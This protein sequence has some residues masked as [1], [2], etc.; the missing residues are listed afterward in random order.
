[1]LDIKEIR[2]N[3]DFYQKE[4][5]SRKCEVNLQQL[6]DLDQSRKDIQTQLQEVQEKRN[7]LSKQ[8]GIKKSQGED[9]TEIMQEVGALK[10]KMSELSDQEADV[11][12]QLNDQLSALP[13]IAFEDV[14]EGNSEDENKEIMRHG[15]LCDFSFTPRDHEEI[16]NLLNY[17]SS[18]DAAK[19]SGARF[20]ILYDKL[21]RLERALSQFMLDVQTQEFGYTEVSPPL[22]VK[23]NVAYGTGQLPKFSEDLFKTTNDFYLIPT[24]EMPLTNIVAG[25]ILDEDILPIRFTALTPCFRSEAGAAGKDTKGMIRQ[26][27]F[28][29][30]ELVSIT[31]QE[32]SQDEHERMTN[33]A[34]EILKRLELPY[35]KMLLC[36]GDMGFSARKTYDLEVWLPGQNQYREISSCSNCS[37]FQARRMNARYRTKSDKKIHFAH[38]LNGSGLAVGRALIAVIENYQTE[39]GHIRV[40]EV[41]QPYMNGLEII[42]NEKN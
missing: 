9:A 32:D 10:T 36:R 34:E 40:P 28:Y 39:E 27:Q 30:V 22:L 16:G 5:A 17:M 4:L 38:T 37:D 12:K 24:A 26:H 42:K 23:D 18:E 29:K 25:E 35:R 15:D 20:T 6:I 11:K 31:K 8:I 14:P 41:L 21:A 3:P 33:A 2:E 7:S 1:M 19:L 13:N